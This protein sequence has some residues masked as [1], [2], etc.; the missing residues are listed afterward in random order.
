MSWPRGRRSG[1]GFTLIELM[2]V[3]LIIAIFATLASPFLLGLMREGRS[4]ANAEQ[5]ALLF[6]NGRM[7][8]LGRGAGVLGR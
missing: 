8:A 6:T 1:R 4:R 3:V 5:L 7:R 2:A